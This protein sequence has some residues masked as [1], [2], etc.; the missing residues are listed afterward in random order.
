MIKMKN[1]TNVL[2]KV[3]VVH[4]RWQI[5]KV[6]SI[7]VHNLCFWHYKVFIHLMSKYRRKKSWLIWLKILRQVIHL[8]QWIT[9]HLW[10]CIA[11]SL[12]KKR[13][14]HA[15]TDT[16]DCSDRQQKLWS[17]WRWKSAGHLDVQKSP[18]DIVLCKICGSEFSFHHSTSILQYH[19]NTKQMLGIPL[20][21]RQHITHP[22]NH[23]PF[24]ELSR[25][26]LRAEK[27]LLVVSFASR[28]EN[29]LKWEWRRPE[30][31]REVGGREFSSEC[32]AR[33]ID[34]MNEAINE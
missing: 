13:Y 34:M 12:A 20:T 26:Y 7:S 29:G 16:W 19:I 1:N 5:S 17:N 25:D 33:T 28:E 4:Y 10:Q 11:G 22:A 23:P 3:Y 18:M 9:E 27:M 6:V 32:N 31:R 2:D 30:K 15:C 24:I 21:F 8:Q 14:Y